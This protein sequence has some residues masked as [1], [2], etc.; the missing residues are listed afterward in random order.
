LNMDLIH[1]G[2]YL[3]DGSYSG[4]HKPR[5]LKGGTSVE[6]EAAFGEILVLAD[7]SRVRTRREPSQTLVAALESGDFQTIQKAKLSPEEYEAIR[8]RCEENGV[9]GE[10]HAL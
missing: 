6:D 9:L 7:E 8:R 3:G 1:D 4:A 10:Q 5:T 2:L